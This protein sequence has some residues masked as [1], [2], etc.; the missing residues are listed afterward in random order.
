MKTNQE[1]VSVILCGGGSIFVDIKESLAD[2]TEVSV[3]PCFSLSK[4]SEW[5]LFC[6]RL[7]DHLILQCVTLSVLLSVQ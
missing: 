5:Y 3:L 6:F 7:F 4:P 1:P 2:V